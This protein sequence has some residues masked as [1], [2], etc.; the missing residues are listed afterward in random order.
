[1]KKDISVVR[2]GFQVTSKP[3]PIIPGG[4]VIQGK[5]L[6]GIKKAVYKQ[7]KQMDQN[8]YARLRQGRDRHEGFPIGKY[9]Q[10][11][12]ILFTRDGHAL[13]LGDHF[14]GRPCFLIC[15]GPSFANIDQSKLNLPGVLTMGINNS[16]K[17]Y[18]PDMWICVDDPRNFVKS[19]WLDPK[20]MK[21]AP[22]CHGEKKLFDSDKWEEM[23]VKVGDCPNVFH[24][25]RNEHFQAEQYLFEDT[26]NW[27]NHKNYGGG[28]SV[29]LAAIRILFFLGIR[30]IFL[31][32]ADFD[33]DK[34]VQ[35]HFDQ[36]KDRGAQK[37]NNQTYKLLIERFTKLK[38]IF[39]ENKLNVYNCNL[40]SNLKVFPFIEFDEAVG[41]MKQDF[42]EDVK[43][44]RTRGLYD[45]QANLRNAQKRIDKIKEELEKMT[46]SL[47]KVKSLDDSSK[48][49]E[50][51]LDIEQKIE[52]K[53]KELGKQLEEQRQFKL[54]GE[55]RDK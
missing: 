24:Y 1:V 16:V 29:M 45:R 10:T 13:Y 12:P 21:F 31:L 42:P 40:K 8:D 9:I 50:Q 22:L 35:Y 30:D 14:R 46:K 25:R 47:N 44:E 43:E 55:I 51:I 39:E 3:T 19:V 33:M 37:S 34:D 18:R 4:K 53:E 32:G 7:S 23:S 6:G 27:G 26:V 54:Y 36:N 20:I 28:R 49:K 11:P 52:Q 41:Y 15:G 38:P 5:S 2:Q 17:S 48:V